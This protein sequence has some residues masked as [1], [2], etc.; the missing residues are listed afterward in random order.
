MQNCIISGVGSCMWLSVITNFINKHFLMTSY[1][2]CE[3]AST[4]L[5]SIVKHSCII[6]LI[7]NKVSHA[8]PQNKQD[9]PG[10]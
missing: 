6:H 8:M 4:E 10:D 7:T 2:K 3:L 5:G 9:S 1:T